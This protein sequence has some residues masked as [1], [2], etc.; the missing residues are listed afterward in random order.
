MF[1]LSVRL[2]E[3]ISEP[4]SHL[5]NLNTPLPMMIIGYNLSRA[6]FKENRLFSSFG[7]VMCLLCRLVITPVIFAAVMYICGIRG[8]VLIACTIAASAPAAANTN[9]FAVKFSQDA[10]LSAQLV[11]VTTLL[12]A[13][14]M[15]LIVGIV[16]AIA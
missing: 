15:P 7:A 11:S 8:A 14:T 5:A 10:S 2:P 3:V 13:L 16:R 12:S 1:L 6:S 4:M 9:M